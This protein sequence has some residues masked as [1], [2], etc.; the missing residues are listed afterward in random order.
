MSAQKIRFP[1]HILVLI[2]LFLSIIFI[3]NSFAQENK[4]RQFENYLIDYVTN[5]RVPS[6]SAGVL[7]DGKIVWLGVKGKI[8]LENNVFANISSVYRIASVSKPITAVAVM[9]LYERGLIDLDKDVRTY[10][11]SFP[12]KKWKFTIRQ[13][14]SHTSGIRGYKEGEFDSKIFY[15][16]TSEALKVFEYDTLDFEPGTKFEYSTLAYSLLAAVIESVT[17]TSFKEYLTKNIFEPA[18]MRNTYVDEQREIIPDRAKGY[19]KN[20]FREFINAPLADLSLKVAGGGLLSTSHDLLLFAKSLLDGKLIKHSTLA[21]MTTPHK[22]KNGRELDYG[23]GFALTYD[24]DSLISFYHIGGGTGFMSMLY[25]LPNDNLATVDLVN[26]NDRDLDHPA[27]DLAKIELGNEI[28]PPRKNV[29]D[30]LMFTYRKT[31]IDSTI[32]TYFE[33]VSTDSSNYNLS[34]NEILNFSRDLLGLGKNADAIIFLKVMQR[35]FQNSYTLLVTIADAYLK[36]KNMGLALKYYRSAYQLN[37]KDTYVN[38][39]I[40]QLSRK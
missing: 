16:S 18:E 31:G 32:K 17:K 22:L 10:L 4:V 14:L 33:I 39:M 7:K 2:H 35:R 1:L 40:K 27:E 15:P 26:I 38:K 29:S 9:Q 3:S 20:F 30:D 19:E 12:A 25:F 23:L 13:I 11:P 5:K 8:D 21:L 37:S 24:Q 28:H 36:D 6:I 34:E